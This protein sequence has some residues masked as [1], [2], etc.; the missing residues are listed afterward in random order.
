[1]EVPHP[2]C[3]LHKSK[4]TR[5]LCDIAKLGLGDDVKDSGYING[6]SFAT[7]PTND[8][9][10]S[11]FIGDESEDDRFGFV[12]LFSSSAPVNTA[13][14]GDHGEE[15]HSDIT[16]WTYPPYLKPKRTSP[17]AVPARSSQMSGT[18]LPS[19]TT[20][21]HS[22]FMHEHTRYSTSNSVRRL[23]VEWTR[24]KTEKCPSSTKSS[25]NDTDDELFRMD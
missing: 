20:C 21:D 19:V 14:E 24:V 3:K 5:R 6:D 13:K 11:W 18:L 4:T 8:E 1:M 17:V 15:T 10:A 12:P 9:N 25:D 7:V 23:D 16:T 22:K 2:Q